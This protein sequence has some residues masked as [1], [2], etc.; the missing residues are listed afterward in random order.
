MHICLANYTTLHN[1]SHAL[2]P[3]RL[4]PS[5]ESG[6]FVSGFALK[7]LWLEKQLR[8][9]DLANLSVICIC[10]QPA[11]ILSSC[12][13]PTGTWLQTDSERTDT[14]ADGETTATEVCSIS[15]NICCPRMYHACTFTGQILY[16][17][18]GAY[19]FVLL[20]TTSC[21]ACLFVL[22]I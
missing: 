1:E 21:N 22:R 16:R 17:S 19:I 11:C 12:C 15:Y 4:E 13:L 18:S 7:C 9:V 5:S 8:D 2:C 6:L 20:N 10:W 3:V 14:A